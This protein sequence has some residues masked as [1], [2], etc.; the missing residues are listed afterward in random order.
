[1]SHLVGQLA[2]SSKA[3][4]CPLYVIRHLPDVRL[5]QR[6]VRRLMRHVQIIS[7][8]VCKMNCVKKPLGITG[9][10]TDR[11]H[12]LISVGI[13][14]VIEMTPRMKRAYL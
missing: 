12:C 1:M 7:L 14:N 11:L 6:L 9:A 2:L 13:N 10:C 4:A 3:S 5:L 8:M